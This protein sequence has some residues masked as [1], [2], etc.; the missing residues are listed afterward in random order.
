MPSRSNSYKGAFLSHRGSLQ[1][2]FFLRF[3]TYWESC[4]ATTTTPAFG[5]TAQP[6]PHRDNPWS[7]G[8]TPVTPKT[9]SYCS[10]PRPGERVS[11]V[12]GVEFPS[13]VV[14]KSVLTHLALIGDCFLLFS[15][16]H[17][18]TPDTSKQI[19]THPAC[20]HMH[21]KHKLF[22]TSCSPT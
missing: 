1:H 18:I 6:A 2:L 3:W 8:S 10:A 4:A 5:W 13:Y 11:N 22:R 14:T 15:S 9:L 16:S 17:I 20:M 19:M 12:I 7:T 21:E